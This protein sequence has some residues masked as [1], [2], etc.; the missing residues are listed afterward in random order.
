MSFVADLRVTLSA[1]IADAETELERS[2][3]AL[4]A[5]DGAEPSKPARS[6]VLRP[7]TARKVTAADVLAAIPA[8]GTSR[9]RICEVTGASEP[10]VLALLKQ[11]EAAGQVRREGERRATRWLLITDEDRVAARAAELAA[12]QPARKPRRRGSRV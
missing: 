1:R 6:R 9:A 5:Y 12:A 11:L 3:A 7:R 4:A 10:A 2:R 8:E